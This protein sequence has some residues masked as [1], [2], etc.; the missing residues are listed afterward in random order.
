[1][2][3]LALLGASGHGKVVADIA[4]SAGWSEVAFFDDAWPKVSTNGRWQV[5]GNSADLLATASKF[6]G[7]LVAIG[8]CKVRLEKQQALIR[9]GAQMATLVHPSACVSAFAKLGHG[10]VVMPGA[11][12]NIDADVGDAVI[13]N[14]GATVDHDCVLAQGV[15]I[16][17]GAN[18][19]GNVHVGEKSWIGI[20]AVVRQ[21]ISIGSEVVIGAGAVVVNHVCNAITVVGNPAGPLDEA[22]VS[23]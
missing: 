11:V 5:L 23:V 17:P 16:S 9:A 18:L 22:R 19:S 6:D 4:L 20:G 13:V 10:T 8:N 15:H 3:R 14:T 7:V 2:K 12:V 21:G 1:M